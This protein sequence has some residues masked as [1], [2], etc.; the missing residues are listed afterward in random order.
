MG[1]ESFRRVLAVSGPILVCFAVREESQCF[2]PAPGQRKLIHTVITGMGQRNSERSV[3]QALAQDRPELVLS[4][5]F[6]G[7]LRPGLAL[8]AVL[9]SAESEPGLS[10]RLAE[11]GARP[12][13]FYCSSRIA[14]TAAEKH[15]LWNQT[16]ADAVEMES[17]HIQ[18]LCRKQG[19]RMGIVRV[20]SD[21]P[22]EDL[23]L[24]FND[25]LTRQLSLNYLKL[26]WTLARA[27]G[28]VAALLRFQQRIRSAAEHLGS[29]LEALLGGASR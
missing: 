17:G 25:L 1:N 10:A 26:A 23:P 24:D 18:R 22:D 13:R 6:A 21:G 27:P 11:L 12:A 8:G 5:G 28:R 9:F 7:G 29:V 19:V 4:C 20:I 3:S 15:T 16:G 2:R 14:A